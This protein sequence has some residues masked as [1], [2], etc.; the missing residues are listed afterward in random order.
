[1]SDEFGLI[2]NM[3]V[4]LAVAGLGGLLASLLRQPPVAGYLAAGVVMGPL[5]RVSPV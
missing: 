1:M 2:V 3:T 4:V 5:R